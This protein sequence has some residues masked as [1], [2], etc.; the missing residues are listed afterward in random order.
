MEGCI[1]WPRDITIVCIRWMN[2]DGRCTR[3]SLAGGQAGWARQLADAMSAEGGSA[4]HGRMLYLVDGYNVTRRDPSTASLSLQEQRESIVSRLRVRGRDLLGS[5]RIV[6]VFDGEQG[7]GLSTGGSVPV[8]IV[9]AHQR[10]ADDE[11]VRIAGRSKSPLVVVSSD[12]AVGERAAQASTA[13]VEVRDASTCFEAALSASRKRT[14]GS[15]GSIARDVG[16]PKGAN[17]ITRELKD[18]WLSEED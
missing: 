1:N 15:R 14:R 7:P 3:A 4:Y 5:G 10:S 11:I 6:V 9:Y 2:S 8:E 13:R 17:E 16:L 12:R 18:L